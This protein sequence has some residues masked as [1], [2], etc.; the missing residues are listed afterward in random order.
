M[1]KCHHYI[2]ALLVILGTGKTSIA[3]IIG[4]IFEQEKILSGVGEFTEIHGRD[5]VEKYVGWTAGKVHDTVEQAIGNVLFIDEAYSLVS[6]RRGC[7][8]DEAIATLIK[9]MEDH[10]DEICFIMAGYTDEIKTLIERN[11]GFES[12]IQF[13]LEF[14][15]YNENE[16]LEIFEGFC[17]NE[18]YTMF[19][20]SREFLLEHFKIAKEMTN[21]GNGRYVR[22]LFEKIKFEQADRVVKT[23]AKGIN[24]ITLSDIR[25]TLDSISLD[26]PVKTRTIGF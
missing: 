22:N 4:K 11:P 6:D 5:L 20:E 12:R 16:L 24:I 19:R 7:F 1:E 2:C 25:T 15:N 8:E 10:R 26:K 9:E 21:F 3:R 13:N 17:K 18:K 14:P 23:K